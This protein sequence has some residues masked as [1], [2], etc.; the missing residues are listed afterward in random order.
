[1]LQ[2]CCANVAVGSDLEC[3]ESAKVAPPCWRDF[4]EYRGF[5]VDTLAALRQNATTSRRTPYGL[6]TSISSGYDSPAASALASEVGC[7]E[8]VTFRTGLEVCDT[9]AETDDSGARVAEALG[10]RVREFSRTDYLRA[11]PI[12]AAEFAACGDAFDLQLAAFEQELPRKLFFTGMAGD[13]FW[14]RWNKSPI[15][16][17]GRSFPING[18]SLGE[19][20]LRLGFVHVPVPYFGAVHHQAIHAISNLAEMAPWSLGNA[21][22]RP[23]PR[24]IVEEKGVP[25]H[26]F[27]QSKKGSFAAVLWGR[28]RVGR[29][30]SFEDFYHK[31]RKQVPLPSRAWA[32]VRYLLDHARVAW[33]R[34][35][36]RLGLPSSSLL[37]SRMAIPVPGRPAFLVAWGTSELMARYRGTAAPPHPGLGHHQ[38]AHGR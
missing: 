37:D 1:V 2:C 17:L 21:Y 18:E 14:D 33:T 7:R 23:I 3:Q 28:G 16:L 6:L 36:R 31:H 12:A 8:A 38:P 32:E 27:G 10:L 34:I 20:R 25:R 4:R 9:W 30:T 22:D 35:A 15:R 13:V 29:L 11:D 5:L 24:R 26:W 19:F